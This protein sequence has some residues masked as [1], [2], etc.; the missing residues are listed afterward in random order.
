MLLS[1]ARLGDRDRDIR[2]E[3][4]RIVEIGSIGTGDLDL[5]GRWVVPGLWDNH[6]HFTQWALTSQRLDVSGAESALEAARL[7]AGAVEGAPGIL[8]GAGFRDGLWP[9][10]PTAALLDEAAGR[11]PVVLVSGD[12][13]AAWLNTAAL[14]QFGHAGHPTGLLREDDAFDVTRRLGEVDDATLDGWALAAARDAA[15]RGVVGVADLEMDWNRDTWERRI[16]AG[17]DLLRVQ[18]AVYT[19]HLD[20]AIDEGLRTGLELGPLL[21]VGG[22]KILTDGS[23]NTRT[24]YTHD[25]YPDGGHGM[26]TVPPDELLPLLRRATEGGLEPWVHAIGDHA[27]T[28]ALDAF[29]S[30]G[31]RGRIEHAQLLS[32]ADYPR[33]AELGVVASVQPEHAMDDRDVA[34]AIWG[35]R[36]DRLYAFRSLLDAGA[37]LAF[38]S[39]APVAALDPWVTMEAAVTRSRGG[40]EPWHPEQRISPAEALAASVRSS[41]V[42]GDVA[43]IVAVERDPAGEV[44]RGMPVALT[45]VA[46][47]VTHRTL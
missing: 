27:N 25:E 45:L 29:E 36:T 10:A 8:A 26:L 6:V 31:V 22:F 32:A 20:R 35:G 5:V 46:G 37:E 18:F 38:G 47:Q 19:Q 39:D 23:L 11:V 40:R 28:L 2:I 17:N 14:E 15:A 30:L 34:D 33:F 3:G 16:A 7:V 1:N 24:A 9:D 21:S 12:L 43:D 44:L 41:I 4:G 13:H 42:E